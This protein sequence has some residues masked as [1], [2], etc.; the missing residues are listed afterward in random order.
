VKLRSPRLLLAALCVTALATTTGCGGEDA[1]STPTTPAAATTSASD[2]SSTTEPEPAYRSWIA[3]VRPEVTSIVVHDSPGGT[4]LQLDTSGLGPMNPVAIPNPLPSG[5]P[6]TLMIKAG[7]TSGTTSGSAGVEA[8]G[9]IWH[10]VYLPVRPNGS[11]GWVAD[12]D[13]TLTHTDMAATI[14]LSA[15]TLE[16]RSED[17]PIAT[18]PVAVGEV[19]TPTPIG[20]FFVKELV[21]PPN[22][23]GSYGPLAF[24]LSA[25][26]PTLVDTEAFADGVI[27]I[28]G[29]DQPELIG[30][31]VSHGCVRVR[32]EDILDLKVREVPL[33]MPVTITA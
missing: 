17:Q 4:Q 21:Q 31:D 16:L 20:T 29:T 7:T 9:S 11:T 14:S 1:A 18:Y 10:E 27:G 13:V 28:H 22:P 5:A 33:G 32:N 3:N 15:H 26:S 12:A 2:T 25:F 30:T 19:E 24:G 8:G 23:G 6:T